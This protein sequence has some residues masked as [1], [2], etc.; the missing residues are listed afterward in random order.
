MGDIPSLRNI[1]LAKFSLSIQQLSLK[2]R[3]K[4]LRDIQALKNLSFSR[5]IKGKAL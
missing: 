5:G 2:L 4:G 1:S 3:I